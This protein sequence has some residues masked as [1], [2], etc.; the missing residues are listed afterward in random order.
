MFK[1]TLFSLATILSLSLPVSAKTNSNIVANNT[2]TQSEI[3]VA[4]GARRRQTCRYVRQQVCTYD[5]RHRRRCRYVMK[6]VCRN[7]SRR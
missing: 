3:V 1:M 5:R 6:R 4:Q 2:N 7:V